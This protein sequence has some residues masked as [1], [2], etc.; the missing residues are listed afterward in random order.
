MRDGV[1]AGLGTGESRRDSIDTIATTGEW[2]LAL[3]YLCEIVIGI[4]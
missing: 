3:G 4:A 1:A 2:D